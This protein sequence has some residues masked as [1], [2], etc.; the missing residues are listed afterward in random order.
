M[1]VEPVLCPPSMSTAE[2]ERRLDA[3]ERDAILHPEVRAW[4]DVVYR[5]ALRHR[6]TEGDPFEA[7]LAR[8]CAV[9]LLANVH[10]MLP[11]KADPPGEDWHQG[12]GYTLR[13]EAR[14]RDCEDL[15]VACVGVLR[16][17]AYSWDLPLRARRRRIPL[18]ARAQD[19]FI[20]EVS[21]AGGAWEAFEP[22]LADARLGETPAE[23]VAR[24]A[25]EGIDG[26]KGALERAV[27]GG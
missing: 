2:R 12:A 25:A 15:V 16:T 14:Y 26:A 18:P 1:I 5:E 10:A 17:I 27:L 4:A 9:L 6:D 21:I 20:A 24:R 13:P 3:L 23:V 8:E 19:H 7:W 11:W 22:S